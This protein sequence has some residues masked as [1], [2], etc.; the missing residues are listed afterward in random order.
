MDTDLKD[1]RIIFSIV[2]ILILGALLLLSFSSK[3][4]ASSDLEGVYKSLTEHMKEDIDS[5]LKYLGC[6]PEEYYDY[7]NQICFQCDNCQPCFGYRLVSREDGEKMNSYGF[8]LI[9]N[10]DRVRVKFLDFCYNGLASGMGCNEIKGNTIECESFE[11]FSDI[12]YGTIECGELDIKLKKGAKAE[13]FAETFC[14]F[15]G[16]DLEG[17]KNSSSRYGRVNSYS[18]TSKM[19][20]CGDY[21]LLFME[22]GEIKIAQKM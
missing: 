8:P 13:D 9:R 15:K 12:Q 7:G 19:A 6:E 3:P 2:I 21:Q 4:K 10:I 16:K 18:T 14:E 22:N 5:H 20:L 1:K 11:F 17:I